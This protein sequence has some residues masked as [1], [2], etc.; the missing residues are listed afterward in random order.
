MENISLKMRLLLSLIACIPGVAF[1][2]AHLHSAEPAQDS[3]VN[4]K[5]HQ[6]KLHFSEA[7][8]VPLCSVEVT[9]KTSEMKNLYNTGPIVADPKD[10]KVLEVELRGFTSER[11]TFNVSWQ[12]VSK[13]GH[14][15]N[16]KYPFTYDPQAKK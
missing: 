11:T 15:M 5:P 10:P 12:V 4:K 8:E 16:G 2:H 13:D 6:I 14:K 9:N 3:V 7:L 1:A